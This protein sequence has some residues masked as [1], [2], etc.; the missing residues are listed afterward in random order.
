VNDAPA[1]RAADIG[2]AMGGRGSDVAREAA[3]I[4]LLEDDFDSIVAAVRRGRTV[5]ANLKSAMAYLFGIHL[6]IVALSVVPV[7]AQWPLVLLPVHIA[8]LHLIIDPACSIVFEAEPIAPDTMQ[9]PPRPPHARLF[10][11]RVI[12]QGLLQGSILA[13]IVLTVFLVALFRGQ[14]ELEARALTFTTLVIANLG[15]ILTCRAGGLRQTFTSPNPSLWWV[16]SGALSLL[17]LV[18]Y[19]PALRSLF[20]F[21]FLHGSDIAMCV[22]AALV[23]VGVFE[24]LERRRA[25]RT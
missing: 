5:Y 3:T 23:G 22:A 12:R 1:L 21:S 10:G 11:D 7:V 9:Q 14:G 17:G 16:A 25:A 20:R 15:L 2:I 24:W 4:V 13:L 18:L 8:F 19:V 6:P